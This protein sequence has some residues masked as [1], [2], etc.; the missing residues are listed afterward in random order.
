MM[1]YSYSGVLDN[2]TQY[3]CASIVDTMRIHNSAHVHTL[4]DAHSGTYIV[5]QEVGWEETMQKRELEER[6]RVRERER[7][8]E[9]GRGKEREREA[10]R[11]REREEKELE[12]VLGASSSAST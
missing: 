5:I 2:I 6:E 8:R 10:K 4:I 1:I 9:R 7:Q 12:S 11:E 3:W